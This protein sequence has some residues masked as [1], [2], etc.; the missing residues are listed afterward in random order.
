MHPLRI[1]VSIC[2]FFPLFITV[3]VTAVPTVAYKL[4]TELFVHVLMVKF[5]IPMILRSAKTSMSAILRDF[6]L[7]DVPTSKPVTTAPVRRGTSWTTSIIARPRTTPTPFWS[8]AIVGPSS[9]PTWTKSP[10]NVSPCPWK[11]WWPPP[12]T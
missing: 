11:T 1:Y 3:I 8:L 10:S 12:L 7:K 5:S 2:H 4:P 6:V 9:L